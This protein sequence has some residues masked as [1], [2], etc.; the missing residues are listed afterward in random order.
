MSPPGR[1]AGSARLSRKTPAEVS[2]GKAT[3]PRLGADDWLRAALDIM[4]DEGISGVKVQRLCERLGVTKGSFYWHFTDLDAFLGELARRWAEDGA[5]LHGRIDAAAEPG[6]NLL[7]AM[8]IFADRRNRNLTRAMRDWAQND[9]RARAAIRKA[10]QALFEQV[11]DVI[12]SLGFDEAEAEVRAKILY[13]A[14]VGFA[15]VGSLGKRPS[16]QEQLAAT[17]ELLIRR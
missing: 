16:G 3:S 17:W 15:H 12:E 8:R 4:V 7:H 9:A 10:D 13:Y 6:D 1:A 14:G 11:K 2:A 5:Q